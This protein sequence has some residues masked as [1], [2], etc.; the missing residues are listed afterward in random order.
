MHAPDLM[1]I[2]SLIPA[3]IFSA[4]A[5]GNLSLG[6]RGSALAADG[7]VNASGH[8][9]ITVL[10]S[11]TAGLLALPQYRVA[12][13]M[14]ASIAMTGLAV[15]MLVRNKYDFAIPALV[16]LATLPLALPGPH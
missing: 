5:A 9:F 10:L 7:G 11:L 1:S 4:A 15:T 13:V 12:G 16:A 2:V 8:R 6:V 3:V 14:I